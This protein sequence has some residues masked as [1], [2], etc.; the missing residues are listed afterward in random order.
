V[1]NVYGY[2]KEYIFYWILAFLFIFSLITYF[3]LHKLNKEV[4]KGGIYLANIPRTYELQS[5]NKRKKAWYAL[6]YTATI[7]FIFGLKLENGAV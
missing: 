5:W 7:F 1:W 3:K 2:H 4:S 6:M